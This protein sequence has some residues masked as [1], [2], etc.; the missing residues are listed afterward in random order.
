MSL[1][2]RRFSSELRFLQARKAEIRRPRPI[3]KTIAH[4][5][6]PRGLSAY[7]SCSPYVAGLMLFHR[8]SKSSLFNR[9]WN[10]ASAGVTK[11]ANEV[12]LT[13]KVLKSRPQKLST[14]H[15][16]SCLVDNMPVILIRS[17]AMGGKSLMEMPSPHAI[18]SNVC[19]YVVFSKA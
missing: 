7:W 10:P 8:K 3:S 12:I 16:Y 15:V 17:Q 2:T 9:L 18:N 6:L 4:E 19:L 1:M 5:L 11:S 13:L 14:Y